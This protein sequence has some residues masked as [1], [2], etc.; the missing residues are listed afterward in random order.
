MKPLSTNKKLRIFDSGI[1]TQAVDPLK[2]AS[3]LLDS[4]TQKQ[5]LSNARIS[6]F[7]FKI[8]L[9]VFLRFVI[10]CLNPGAVDRHLS[11]MDTCFMACTTIVN[12]MGEAICKRFTDNCHRNLRNFFPLQPGNL[13]PPAYIS[14]NI[15]L[16]RL[17]ETF[18]LQSRHSLPNL[19][20]L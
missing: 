10:I 7:G 3:E 9:Y 17:W 20:L 19:W 14:Q 15:I 12:R 4:F 1:L 13:S 11:G 6:Y 2:T 5:N 16:C 18:L 8:V